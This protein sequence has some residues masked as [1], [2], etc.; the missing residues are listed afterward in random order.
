MKTV[1]TDSAE[2]LSRHNAEK[3]KIQ[4]YAD[5]TQEA[6]VRRINE[7]TERTNAEYAEAKE[8]EKR[9]IEENVVSSRKDVYRVPASPTY[10]DAEIAQVHAAFRSAWDSGLIATANPMAAQEELGEILEQAERTG[11]SLLAR[12]A[13]HRGLDLGLQPIVD[14]YLASRPREAKALE[15]YNKATEEANQASS[16]EH[17]LSG[18][19][20]ERTLQ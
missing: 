9:R 2:I 11:D 14:R 7:L 5:L 10:S 15:R 12:A 18:A 17:L 1:A 8:A 16:I 3:A 13:Y 4:G 6:K 20:A 19:L